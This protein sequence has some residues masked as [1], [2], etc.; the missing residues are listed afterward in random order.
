MESKNSK[1]IIDIEKLPDHVII[2]V[3]IRTEV[4]DWAQISCVKKQ[5]ASLF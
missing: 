2:E 5:W 1:E 3:F 4:S